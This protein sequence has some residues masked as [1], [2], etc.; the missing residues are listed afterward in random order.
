M[1]HFNFD[2]EWKDINYLIPIYDQWGGN[3][4]QVSLT[5]GKNIIINN[6]TATVVKKLAKVFAVDLTQL[7]R[8]YGILVGR[9]T[10]TPLPLHPDLILIPVKIREPLAKDE[11]A[12]GYVLKNK[13][14]DFRAIESAI[15]RFSF[16]DGTYLDCLQSLTSVNLS[17]AHAEIISRECTRNHQSETVREREEL[18]SV[19]AAVLGSLHKQHQD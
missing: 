19:L 18:Y 17:L 6:K 16:K 7:K 13:I 4:T 10:S 9:K 2:K 14:A 11:G 12:R 3:S 5:G 1:N 8:K 15:T